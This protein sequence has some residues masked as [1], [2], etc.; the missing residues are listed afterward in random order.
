VKGRVRL[1]DAVLKIAELIVILDTEES[2]VL[3]E[4]A[5]Y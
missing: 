2:G 4:R 3:G 1:E 5:V